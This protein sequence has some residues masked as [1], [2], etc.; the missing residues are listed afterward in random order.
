MKLKFFKITFLENFLHIPNIFY[1]KVDESDISN[2]IHHNGDH[3]GSG[4]VKWSPAKTVIGEHGLP[5]EMGK[6]VN[7]PKSQEKEK[8]EKFKINQFNLMASEM[9]SLNRSLADV[10]LKS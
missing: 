7:I 10:R 6:P 9:I 1:S 3:S 2:Q 8:N 4:L 5:G